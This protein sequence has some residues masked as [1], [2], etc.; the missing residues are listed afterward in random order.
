MTSTVSGV[1]LE[2]LT[3]QKPATAGNV[4]LVCDNPGKDEN[5]MCFAYIKGIV[6]VLLVV[7]ADLLKS[8]EVDRISNGD[9]M[10]GKQSNSQRL[11]YK[12]ICVPEWVDLRDIRKIFIKYVNRNLDLSD[13]PAPEVAY[14]AFIQAFPCQ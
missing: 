13:K 9:G 4:K 3:V 1:E 2:N 11:T 8:L 6:D 14:R 5:N 10:E 7:H 12:P